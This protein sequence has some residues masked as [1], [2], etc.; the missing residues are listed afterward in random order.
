MDRRHIIRF[1]LFLFP[2]HEEAESLRAFQ[3]LVPGRGLQGKPPP[4]PHPPA[5]MNN[6]SLSW[7]HPTV[8]KLIE[9]TKGS[10]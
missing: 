1:R 2:L 10:P 7:L 8:L 6:H 5:T 3:Q 4:P 9:K